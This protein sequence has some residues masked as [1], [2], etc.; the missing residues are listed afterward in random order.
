[1][2]KLAMGNTI[3]SAEG[4]EWSQKLLHDKSPQK[5]GTRQGSN[6]GPLNLQLDV[7]PTALRSL[8][9]WLMRE[10]YSLAKNGKWWL[11]QLAF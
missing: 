1:M 2:L 3:E 5:Y 9:Y 10:L 11:F 7:L 4:E 6:S 8:V